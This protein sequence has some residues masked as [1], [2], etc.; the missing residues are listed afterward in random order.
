MKKLL[1]TLLISSTLTS[2]AVSANGG[3]DLWQM[4]GPVLTQAFQGRVAFEQSRTPEQRQH[5]AHLREQACGHYYNHE[6]KVQCE[7]NWVSPDLAGWMQQHQGGVQVAQN[8]PAQAQNTPTYGL[9]QRDIE[10]AAQTAKR[11]HELAS[12]GRYLEYISL[13]TEQSLIESKA[14]FIAEFKTGTPEQLNRYLI[15]HGHQPMTLAQLEQL[16]PNEFR[17]IGVYDKKLADEYN[18]SKTGV[19]SRILEKHANPDGTVFVKIRTTSNN[20]PA[21]DENHIMIKENG[22]WRVVPS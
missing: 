14:K 17:Y 3:D 5:D 6:Q 22:Q 13:F 9:S 7:A 12:A 10:E 11:F 20:Y 8:Q 15:K 4:F 1:S 19:K 21:D 2:S 18:A 16:P